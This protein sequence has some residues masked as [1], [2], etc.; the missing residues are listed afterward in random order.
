VQDYSTTTA[1]P[2]GEIANGTDPLV[3]D[4]VHILPSELPTPPTPTP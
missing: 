1:G 2:I 3:F 4:E